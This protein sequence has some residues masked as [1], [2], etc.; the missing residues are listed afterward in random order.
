LREI[1]GNDNLL[2]N[3]ADTSYAA[4]DVYRA[5]ETPLAVVQPATTEEVSAA[6]SAATAA[7]LAIFPRGGGMSYSDAFLPDRKDSIIVDCTRMN[8][9]R[10]INANDLFVT[11]EAGCTWEQL[12]A[13]LREHD[14]R[15]IFWGPMSGKMSTIGG[16]ISQGAVTF[17]S[18]R[19]GSSLSATLGIE[20]VLADG[21]IVTTGSAAQ[22]NHSA[23]YREYGPDMTGLFCGDSGALGIKTAVTLRLESRP[24]H[25]SGLSFSFDDFPSLVEAVRLISRDKLASETFG[26]ETAL[27]KMVAG[28]PDLMTDTKQMLAMI[29]GADN[30]LRAVGKAFQIALNG[31]RFLDKSKFLVNFLT[32]ASS[33][34]E[35]RLALSDI[36][37]AVGDNGIEVANTV[38]T[39]TQAT[40]F[41]DPMVLGPGGR[42]LLPLHGVVPFSRAA[43]LQSEFEDYLARKKSM[44][45]K[46]DIQ[47]FVVYAVC[48]PAGFLWECV[49][50]WPDDWSVLHKK[51]MPDEILKTMQE[52]DA[53]PDTREKVDVIK[54]ELVDLMY[55]HSATHFQIGRT[56][57]YLR[58]RNAAF[59][60]MLQQLKTSVDPDNLMNPGALGL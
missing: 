27:V 57:P 36:R 49:I 58:D 40:P 25:A 22:A 28:T 52:S 59:T 48:G 3:Q 33:A 24:T 1:V 44:H 55:K 35:L 16:A 15:T 9:I 47:I 26:A 43:A 32:D 8:A 56:Y 7:G 6:V 38:A 11:V 18:S 45:E 50:Y 5:G 46:Y 51:T 13:A 60:T 10:E 54:Q 30:P 17:G 29:R 42:R 2:T 12:D 4:H 14:V 34:K 20:V 19:N 41:P 39:L 37:S 21:K 31:R 23:F 53:N